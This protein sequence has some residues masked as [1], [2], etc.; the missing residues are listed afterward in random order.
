MQPQVF[1]GLREAEVEARN[2]WRY[3]GNEWAWTDFLINAPG[4]R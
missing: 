1:M 2:N 3:L 4:R